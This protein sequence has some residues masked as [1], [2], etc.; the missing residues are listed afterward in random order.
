MYT[1]VAELNVNGKMF[2]TQWVSRTTRDETKFSGERDTK[3]FVYAMD[4]C[5]YPHE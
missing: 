5:I 3:C 4:M 1:R 2:S